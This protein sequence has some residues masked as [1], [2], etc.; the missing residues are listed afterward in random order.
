MRCG[1][2]Q[3]GNCYDITGGCDGG[4]RCSEAGHGKVPVVE[5]FDVKDVRQDQCA[6]LAGDC[7][8]P[9]MRWQVCQGSRWV[10][11]LPRMTGVTSVTYT[12]RLDPKEVRGIGSTRVHQPKGWKGRV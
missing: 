11:A 6:V 3:I 7:S 12:R 2:F 4:S 5:T 9:V 8:G 1:T 10:L